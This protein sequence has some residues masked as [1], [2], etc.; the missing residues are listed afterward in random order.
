MP[1]KNGKGTTTEIAVHP[2]G[3]G[4]ATF[5]WRVSMATVASDGPFSLFPDVDR[6]LSI[7]AG[8]GLMLTIGD[9][10]PIRIVADSEPLSFPADVPVDATLLNGGIE[11]LNVMTRRGRLSH[12]VERLKVSGSSLQP[13]SNGTTLYLALGALRFTC[14][15]QEGQLAPRDCLLCEAGDE[16][17]TLSGSGSIVFRMDIDTA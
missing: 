5:D 1:W 2:P 11:D 16:P 8:E 17:V 14:G 15:L 4:L 12:R 7:I 9:A 6:T 3:A 10:R 13:P